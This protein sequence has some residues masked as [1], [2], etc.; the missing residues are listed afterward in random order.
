MHI[1]AAERE[2]GSTIAPND[3]VLDDLVRAAS[4]AE[5]H[6]SNSLAR[7][8]FFGDL[9]DQPAFVSAFT[10]AVLRLDRYG[11]RDAINAYLTM[12]GLLTLWHW[13]SP[14]RP[15]WPLAKM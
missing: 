2:E 1:H 12:Q 5:G 14:K 9:A 10:T 4:S 13:R 15:S 6:A 11:A 7:R 3:P 8:S